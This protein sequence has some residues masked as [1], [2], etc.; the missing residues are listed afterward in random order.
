MNNKVLMGIVAVAILLIAG[1]LFLG[2]GATVSAIGESKIKAQPD[3]VSIYLTI[4]NTTETAQEVQNNLSAVSDK[5]LLAMLKLDLAKEDVQLDSY[6][7]N[8]NYVWDGRQQYQKGFSGYQ[9]VIVKVKSFNKVS[10]VVDASIG[11]GALVSAINFELSQD[12]QNEYKAQALEAA[13]KDAQIKAKATASGLGKSLGKLV[14]VQNNEYNYYPYRYYSYDALGASSEN[15]VMAKQAAVD[16]APKDLEIT[17]R[18]AVTYKL[19]WF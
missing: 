14:S 13:G 9:S 5:L 11:S 3:E 7:V 6:G 18:I 17:A 1:Y 19:G 12:K 15:A 16:L 10:E 8:P 2:N 4:Q